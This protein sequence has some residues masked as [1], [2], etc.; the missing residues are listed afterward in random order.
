MSKTG[1]AEMRPDG[2]RAKGLT[3][4][5]QAIPHIMPKR[6]DAQNYVTEYVDEEVIKDYIRR[7]RRERESGSPGCPL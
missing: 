1:G 3:A 5:E 2:R 7:V 4:I 6:V